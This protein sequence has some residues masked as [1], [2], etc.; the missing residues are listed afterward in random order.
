M[1][2]HKSKGKLIKR[3]KTKEIVVSKN[4]L[5]INIEYVE[6]KYKAK[7]LGDFSIKS[8][9]SWTER[10]LALFYQPRPKKSLGHTN[11]F[12]IGVNFTIELDG[13]IKYHTAYITKGGLK[14]ATYL[15]LAGLEKQ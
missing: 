12:A 2:T 15:R 5:P 4:Y 11:Y 7:Y 1:I 3:M 6:N 9:D 8:K 14:M 10:P 13:G